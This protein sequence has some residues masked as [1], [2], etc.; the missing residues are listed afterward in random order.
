MC[1]AAVAET[2]PAQTITEGERYRC[3]QCGTDSVPPLRLL[4]ALVSLNEIGT[5][6]N[7]IGRSEQVSIKATLRLI[8]EGAINVVPESTAVIYTYD[9]IQDTFDPTSRVAA[10]ER[11]PP[12]EYDVP[13]RMAWDG[14]PSKYGGASSHMKNLR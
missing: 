13:A 4:D 5:N 3:P 1:G 12:V 8:V 7:R 6:I 11:T 9:H 2:Q 10:G 14:V